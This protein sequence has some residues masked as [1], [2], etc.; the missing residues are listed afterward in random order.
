MATFLDAPLALHSST[1]LWLND[2]TRSGLGLTITLVLAT[3]ALAPLFAR[4]VFLSL[5]SNTVPVINPPKLFEPTFLKSMEFP[6][7]G[8]YYYREGQKRFPNQP[9]KLLSN[10]GFVTIL[11]ADRAL[12]VRN[13]ATLDFRKAFGNILPDGFL[14]SQA[15]GILDHP[16][17]VMQR[18]VIQH[19]TKQP[20]DITKAMST[21][22]A[23]AVGKSFG[24]NHEWSDVKLYDPVTDVV[25]R[26]SSRVFLGDV[27]CRSEEWLNITKSFAITAI[28]CVMTLRAFPPWLRSL[29]HRFSK[30][31]KDFRALY[32]RA[33]TMVDPIVLERRRELADCAAQG[34]PPP[35]HNDVLEWGA[36]ECP[37]TPF[38][39]CALQL[40]LSL[41]S[42]HTTSDLLA[43]TLLYLSAQPESIEALRE[44]IVQILPIHGWKAST[45]AALKRMDSAIKEAQRLK[46]VAL[47]GMQRYVTEDTTLAGGIALRRGEF[48]AVDAGRNWD[49]ERFE[50]PG[51]YSPFRFSEARRR[52]AAEHSHQ[53]TAVTSDNISFGFGK[54]VCPGRFFASS[55]IKIALCHLILKYDWKIAEGSSPDFLTIGFSL[56]VNPEAKVSFR[57]RKEE[58][59]LDSLP[60]DME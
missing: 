30:A 47:A 16:E 54:T 38:D 52:S 14:S 36:K 57:R 21:E 51:Q 3:I 10:Q 11:P 48:V 17:G 34:M 29:V 43:Q 56:V 60:V 46:P 40:T 12:E 42:I 41:A 5:W 1:F 19:L 59:D 15:V 8:A 23:F 35:V 7:R 4:S 22:A 13:V 9:F 28:T 24:D 45:F 37:D 44:E 20:D 58:F 25:A 49:P 50:N 33:Q 39:M 31:G 27:L 55:E 53:L 6:S 18:V 2:M 26:M 32:A